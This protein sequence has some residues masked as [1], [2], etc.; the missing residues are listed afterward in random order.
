MSITREQFLRLSDAQQIE[1]IKLNEQV[2]AEKCKD[3]YYRFFKRAWTIIEPSTNLV[4]SPHIALVCGVLERQAKRQAEGLPV[5]FD[6]IIINIPPSCSKSSICTKVFPSWV[7]LQK[8]AT[9]VIN[10]SYSS[11]LA[12]SHAGKSRDII[13]SEWYQK[14]YGD[15]CR[16]KH[17]E[18]KKTEYTNTGE[19]TRYA[20]GTGGA[21]TGFHAHIMIVDDPINPKQANS[22]AQR[23]DARMFWKETKPSRMLENSFT[24]L[25]MQR[26]HVNDPTGLELKGENRV[27]HLNL[28]AELSDDVKPAAAKAIY[29]NGLLDEHRLPKTRL[30]GFKKDLGS[31]GYAGQYKQ[32]P[33]PKGGGIVKKNWFRYM[34]DVFFPT[35]LVW[36]MWIDGAYTKSTKNDPTG[37]MIAAFDDKRKIVYIKY[38]YEAFLEMPDLLKLVPELAERF[39]LSHHSKVY[40]EPKASGK[41]LKQM[42]NSRVGKLNVLE[43]KN[44]LVSEG[45]TA[46]AQVASPKFESEQVICREGNWNS[47][48]EAQLTGFPSYGKDEAVDLVGYA[49]FQY[50]HR[51]KWSGKG[52]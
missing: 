18:N 10:I 33:F 7:W 13:Q 40:I 27:L 23:E 47:E 8:P 11:T 37:I 31:Y 17:G 44:K 34:E 21:I 28:P 6:T 19:G 5:E 29:E 52:F 39:N 20:A 24:I 2:D 42:L 12:T 25:V 14:H 32:K 45:K 50:Y 22:E 36:D 9:K 1:Y 41:S 26:L 15:I 49:I 4:E 43:I 46:R 30:E 35:G 16:I 3:S 38:F 51:K 48:F